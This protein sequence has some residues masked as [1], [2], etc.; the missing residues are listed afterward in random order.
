MDIHRHDLTDAQ[1]D[2]LQRYLPPERPATGRPNL[3]H[4]QVLNGIFWHLRSDAPWRDTPD[5]FGN[6]QTL[7]S[8]FRRWQR[9]G[10]WEQI[11]A[12]LQAEAETR[13]DLDWSLH[14]V[15]GTSIRAHP[16][17][18]GAKKGAA[19]KPSGAVR[20]GGAPSSTGASSGAASR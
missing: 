8:R 7:Y 14:F 19:I 17:A 18:A 15:D 4:R 3:D 16:H 1:W 10:L 2:H 5:D 9:A 12:R 20:A 11:L 6:W 13:G